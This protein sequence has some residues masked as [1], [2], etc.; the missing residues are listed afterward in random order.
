MSKRV[1]IAED[2]LVNQQ[3][4]KAF[5]SKL[6][7]QVLLA[8]DGVEAVDVYTSVGADMVLMDCNMPNMDGMEA[9]RNIRAYEAEMS[10]PRTPIVALTAH[11]FNEVVG[12]CKESGMDDHLAKPIILEKLR[13]VMV[14]WIGAA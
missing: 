12:Q 7:Y 2:N 11:A 1:L 6:G 8:N 3:V 13:E 14:Q 5:V 9:T 4:A 10:L